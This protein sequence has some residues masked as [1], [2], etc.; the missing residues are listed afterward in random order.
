MWAILRGLQEFWIAVATGLE[1]FGIFFRWERWL[2]MIRENIPPRIA[3]KHVSSPVALSTTTPEIILLRAAQGC[4]RR[5]VRAGI[6]AEISLRTIL[7][8]RAGSDSGEKR[9][10]PSNFGSKTRNCAAGLRS[11]AHWKSSLT[12]GRNTFRN[13]NPTSRKEGGIATRTTPCADRHLRRESSVGR[14]GSLS[15]SMDT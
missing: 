12:V 2:Y 1:E 4:R 10:Q 15:S 7:E 6:H 5:C 9:K 8:K 3:Y 11:S 14:S 13:R